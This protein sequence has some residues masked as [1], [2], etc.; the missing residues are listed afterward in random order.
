MADITVITTVLAVLGGIAYLAFNL[1]RIWGERK[2]QLAEAKRQAS[3]PPTPIP[4]SSKTV[5]QNSGRDSN[6]IDKS[7]G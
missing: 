4:T 6:Y 1:F 3:Q 7:R 5:I 2:R